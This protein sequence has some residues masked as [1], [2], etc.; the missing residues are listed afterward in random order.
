MPMQKLGFPL[1]ERPG[2]T[3]ASTHIRTLYYKYN[4]MTKLSVL[5]MN[6]I[7]MPLFLVKLPIS[8]CLIWKIPQIFH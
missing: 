4:M 8:N 3:S 2:T 6:D 5:S 1:T 7:K